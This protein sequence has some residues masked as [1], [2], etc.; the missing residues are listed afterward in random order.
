MNVKN[1]LIHQNLNGIILTVTK[2]DMTPRKRALELSL[3]YD[4]EGST[5][6]ALKCVLI[7]VNEILEGKNISLQLHQMEY[8]EEVK[9]EIFNLSS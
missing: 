9:E 6:N 5:D 3:R 1:V 7:C 2:I 8:W 4:K